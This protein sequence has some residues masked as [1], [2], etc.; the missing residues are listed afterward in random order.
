MKERASNWHGFRVIERR[1]DFLG[2]SRALPSEG[3][4]G[5]LHLLTAREINDCIDGWL[6]ELAMQAVPRGNSRPLCTQTRID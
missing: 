5:S 6:G 4:A 2:R 1:D 3:Q